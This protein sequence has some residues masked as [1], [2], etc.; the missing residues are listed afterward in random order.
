MLSIAI[1]HEVTQ[2]RAALGTE[3]VL[4]QFDFELPEL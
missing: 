4:Y 1:C 2:Q 3:A